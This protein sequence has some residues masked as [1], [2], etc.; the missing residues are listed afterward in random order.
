MINVGIVRF[1][2][3]DFGGIENQIINIV[4]NLCS[5][6]LH[7]T[8]MTNN[9][10]KFSKVFEEFGDVS[11][12]EAGNIVEASKQLVH[13]ID[14]KKI[15][16]LQSH[17]LRESYIVCLA[18]MRRKKVYHIFR[19]HTYINCSFIS[20]LKKK[21]YH[22]L[23]FLLRKNVDIYLPINEANYNELVKNSKISK[24][25]IEIVYDGVKSLA[26]YTN[27]G[28][29]N[30]RDIV[31]IANFYYGKG[32]DVAIKAL[33]K[34]VKKSNNY[35]LIFIGGDF[36]GE[37]DSN[38]IMKQTKEQVK[39]LGLE[40]NVKFLGFVENIGEVIKDKNIVILPS[41]SEGTPNCLLEA[42]SAKKIVIAS[43]VGGIPEFIEDGKNGFLHE[44]KNDTELC[45]KIE[46]LTKLNYE[47]L[48]NIAE[49]GYKTWN[50][51]YSIKKLCD[52]FET[53]YNKKGEK[54]NEEYR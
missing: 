50:D 54:V 14:E 24:K 42:M 13:I 3:G 37:K 4:S 30:Y 38:S 46:N 18:K 45:D 19:I 43:N 22:V 29:F 12:I 41:Y 44:N 15:S 5:K 28:E 35:N 47:Q 39:A 17:M 9:K 8:L 23:A 10:T 25:K 16:I 20:K 11:Y 52:Y 53:I 48:N 31:M 51:L 49:N 26:E 36:N 27:T 7:F 6:D 2:N 34:L 21:L 40:Q 1:N 33:E 32:H